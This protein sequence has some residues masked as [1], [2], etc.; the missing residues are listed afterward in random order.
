MLF[1]GK[2]SEW[3]HVTI[4]VPQRPVLGTILFIIYINDLETEH[5]SSFSKSADDTKMGG[6]ALRKED[7]EVIQM[8]VIV[9]KLISVI[10]GS[11]EVV[12]KTL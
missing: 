7:C 8:R 10:N 1:N 9:E 11:I 4:R 5:K 12:K 3:F 6:Q 2:P